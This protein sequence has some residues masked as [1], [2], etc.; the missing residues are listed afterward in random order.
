[1][2]LLE[3]GTGLMVQRVLRPI[4]ERHETWQV[5]RMGCPGQYVRTNSLEFE[6]RLVRATRKSYLI[7]TSCDYLVQVRSVGVV[8]GLLET[9]GGPPMTSRD[10]ETEGCTIHG[11]VTP[12]Y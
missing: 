10:R 4:G 9:D 11:W 2:D 5:Q 3:A 12:F 6:I 1:M 8:V 7:W